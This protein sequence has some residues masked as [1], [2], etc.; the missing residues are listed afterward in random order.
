MFFNAVLHFDQC[1]LLLDVLIN[2]LMRLDYKGYPYAFMP[3]H[4]GVLMF[5]VDESACTAGLRI[6]FYITKNIFCIY[7][8]IKISVFNNNSIGTLRF[9]GSFSVRFQF[10]AQFFFMCH[11]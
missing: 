2:N 10:V 7:K 3:R 6:W 1:Q 4:L 11:Y 8:A 5:N 9:S